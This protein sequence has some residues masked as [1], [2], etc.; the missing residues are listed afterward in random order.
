MISAENLTD[1][2]DGGGNVLTHNG[3]R[4]GSIG[5]LY[6]DDE[7]GRP[8]W[9]T[10]KTGLFGTGE[11]FVPLD[12]ATIRGNDIVVPFS[13]DKVK[14]APRIDA[15]GHLS[16]EEQD[17][18]YRYYEQA[19]GT[20][21]TPE[22]GRRNAGVTGTGTDGKDDDRP[23]DMSGP[24][25][26]NAMIRSEERLRVDT[27]S[28]ETGRV[29]LRKY[30]VTENVT[31]TIPVSHEEIRIEREPIVEDHSGAAM[32]GTALTEE[33]FEVTL[34][35]ERPM[36][37]KETVPV[38]RVRLATES[39]PG[40]ETVNE[41]VRKEKIS[42]DGVDDTPAYDT[43]SGTDDSGTDAAGGRHLS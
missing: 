5:Q 20:R 40:E 12:D 28:Q 3:D 41:E 2:A 1:V 25:T 43:A 37:E 24:T 8:N 16:E 14:D 13:K 21:D 31:K 26:D 9:V 18:L 35:S 33:E 17:D 29:R 10:A 23:A 6:V 30:V 38:E 34:H 22:A 27:Q 11:S 32:S 39:V 4:I 7:T 42:A 15:D 19:G 36:V